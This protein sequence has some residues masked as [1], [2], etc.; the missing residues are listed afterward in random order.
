MSKI[1]IELRLI[2]KITLVDRNI[3]ICREHIDENEVDVQKKKLNEKYQYFNK[4]ELFSSIAK[5]FGIELK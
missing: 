3:D 5:I 1:T 2:L 4:I